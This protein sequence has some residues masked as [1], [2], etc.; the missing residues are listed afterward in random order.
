MNNDNFLI[1]DNYVEQAKETCKVIKDP[2]TRSRAVANVLAANMA[3]KYFEEIDADTESGLHNI[4]HIL[5]EHE[6]SDIYIKDSYIDVRIYFNENQLCVPKA[7]F[8]KNLLP[9][10]YMFIKVDEELSGA[11]VSGFITPILVDTSKEKNGYYQVSEDSLIS[12]YDVEA[13]LVQ[14]YSCEIPDDIELQIF[15]YLDGKHDDINEFYKTLLSS[16]DARIMLKDAISAKTILDHISIERIVKEEGAESITEEIENLTDFSES[17]DLLENIEETEAL[18]DT[19][20]AS[21]DEFLLEEASNDTLEEAEELEDDEDDVLSM[22]ETETSELSLDDGTNNLEHLEEVERI[23]ELENTDELEDFSSIEL[24]EVSS[25]DL[26]ESSN[27]S[28]EESTEISLSPEYDV[29]ENIPENNESTEEEFLNQYEV[30]PISETVEDEVP[31]EIV[32]EEN[33][34]SDLEEL[35]S[36]PEVEETDLNNEFSTTITPSMDTIE[37]DSVSIDELEG[38]L[39]ND[40]SAFEEEPSPSDAITE[41]ENTPQIEELFGEEHIDQDTIEEEFI[42]PI[43]KKR[44]PFIPVLSSLALL[45]VLG[46]FGYTKFIAQNEAPTESPEPLLAME[47]P[48]VEKE[49]TQQE[50]MPVE[51][52][53]KVVT[54]QQ[55]NEGNAISI[56]AIEQ[57]LDA[58]ILIS[59]LTVNWEVPTNYLTNNTAKRYFT[60]MGK[61]IRLNL[62]TELLLLNKTPITNKITLELEF[63]KNSNHFKVKNII[64]SSGE[65]SVDTL[66]KETVD[67]T[68][69]LNLKNNMTVFSSTAGNPV[70]VI[71]L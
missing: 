12:Y 31:A 42:K 11:L 70:L 52:V 66:I 2:N 9:V 24:E 69:Q 41:N 5:E 51:T 60:K 62:K 65:P 7:H 50:A 26:L 27:D 68:L 28:L 16:K 59:N 43:N 13:S 36:M 23:Q 15:N 67:K 44:S 46:Y 10:A 61:I 55:T 18:D 38:L 30:L 6:I 71:R 21:D 39:E 34:V 8:E 64:A 22:A 48:S 32:T 35:S 1:E 54:P 45:I 58:S 19:L 25:D 20:E 57:N 47:Q 17:S 40:K 53:E 37:T 4:A 3:G 29:A 33:V 56:P 49:L 14:N 63:D